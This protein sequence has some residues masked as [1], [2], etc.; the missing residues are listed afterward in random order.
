MMLQTKKR[1]REQMTARSMPHVAAL[2][3]F[4]G[5]PTV[6]A[7]SAPLRAHTAQSAQQ[8]TGQIC[9]RRSAAHEPALSQHQHS[10]NQQLHTRNRNRPAPANDLMTDAFRAED[11]RH[12]TLGRSHQGSSAERQPLQHTAH[13]SAQRAPNVVPQDPSQAWPDVPRDKRLD[14]QLGL[15]RSRAEDFSKQLTA[16]ASPWALRPEDPNLLRNSYARFLSSLQNMHA[17]STVIKD[18]YAW[19]FWEEYC[20]RMGTTPIRSDI[21]AVLGVDAF[22]FQRERWLMANAIV[23]WMPTIKGRGGRSQGTPESCGKRL[24]GVCRVLERLGLPTVPKKLIYQVVR[25][26]MRAYALRHG[27]EWLQPNRKDPLPF[28]TIAQLSLLCLDMQWSALQ[29]SEESSQSLK[30]LINVAAESGMRK[31]ELSSPKAVFSKLDL[32]FAH[33]KWAIYGGPPVEPTRAM[34]RALVPGRDY[35]VLYPTCSKADPFSKS[36]GT[37]PIHLLYS[38]ADPI[39]AAACLQKLELLCWS[40]SERCRRT[41]PIFFDHAWKPFSPTKLDTIFKELMAELI[42][43]KVITAAQ[44][45]TYSWH[46]FRASL[47][48]GLLSAGASGPQIQ[49]CCRWLSEK[50]VPVYAAFTAEA[51]SKLVRKALKQDISSALRSHRPSGEL[52]MPS[53]DV[54]E[55]DDSH[56]VRSWLEH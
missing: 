55:Y 45:K 7:W 8:H 50:S 32:S 31:V 54:V 12:N 47:A 11:T 34:L 29:W 5:A 27:P 46:S 3:L 20:K 41:S 15:Q 51:Y 37:K 52:I 22:G 13:R 9:Q 1:R 40:R 44:A 56:N 30:A 21:S 23:D 19:N 2:Q 26:E 49:A 6:K 28:Q 25:G 33:L 14:W 17:D 35:A 16:D 43:L 10:N 38:P 4:Q 48:T 24:D 18:K 36:W 53:G 42:K 39:N